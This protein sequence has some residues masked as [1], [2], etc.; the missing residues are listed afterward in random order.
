MQII[1]RNIITQKAQNNREKPIAS[2]VDKDK[3]TVTE[4]IIGIATPDNTM[5]ITLQSEQMV[6]PREDAIAPVITIKL[7]L[8]RARQY[9]K[10]GK[11][12]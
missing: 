6:E 11:E 7:K 9:I 5:S 4:L 2:E 3:D 12:I 10:K 1:D 8:L